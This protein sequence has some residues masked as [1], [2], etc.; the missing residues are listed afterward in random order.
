MA[1]LHSEADNIENTAQCIMD[2]FKEMNVREGEVLHYQQLYPYL[3]ERYP[4]Y[5][6]VQKEAEHHLAKESFVNP[7]PDGL[8]LTQVGHDHLYGKNA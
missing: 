5:K 3:Q 1:E 2:A 6:D 4:L 7:A 8:M